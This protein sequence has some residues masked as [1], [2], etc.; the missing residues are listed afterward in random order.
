MHVRR[1]S[2]RMAM[3]TLNQLSEMSDW[4]ASGSTDESE[5]KSHAW[6]S[7]MEQYQVFLGILNDEERWQ[8]LS[9]VDHRNLVRKLG[10]HG[11][12]NRGN[13][14]L[15]KEINL[16][17]EDERGGVRTRSFT[18]LLDSSKKEN[19]NDIFS[20]V[21]HPEIRHV[22]EAQLAYQL[23][24]HLDTIYSLGNDSLESRLICFSA[25]ELQDID[26]Q[27]QGFSANL[28]PRM[29]RIQ[30]Q[31]LYSVILKYAPAYPSLTF[32]YLLD[33][34]FL[35]HLIPTQSIIRILLTKSFAAILKNGGLHTQ[36]LEQPDIPRNERDNYLT[37]SDDD[38]L[39]LALLESGIL[40][41][42]GKAIVD[43]T[44]VKALERELEEKEELLKQAQRGQLTL[45]KMLKDIFTTFLSD[46]SPDDFIWIPENFEL[47]EDYRDDFE[48][49]LGVISDP[50]YLSQVSEDEKHLT[51][52]WATLAESE[53][54]NPEV[55]E[56]L[57]YIE[58]DNLDRFVRETQ[59]RF[60][61]RHKEIV[62][63]NKQAVMDYM[64]KN[65]TPTLL[66]RGTITTPQLIRNRQD[67]VQ[68]IL[69]YVYNYLKG[70][71]AKQKVWLPSPYPFGTMLNLID[72]AKAQTQSDEVDP[73]LKHKYVLVH[74]ILEQVFER[75]QLKYKD[76]SYQST[77]FITFNRNR[78]VSQTTL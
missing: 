12:S 71:R 11:L 52:Y 23:L 30:L 62:D 69:G 34:Y 15:A 72:F 21:S 4:I 78:A 14:L 50:R 19:L 22:F 6:R 67:Q 61:V 74:E 47:D 7:R 24:E 55:R 43:Q 64:L 18:L 29:I 5:Y 56:S 20:A 13:P 53:Y 60:A 37:I 27:K 57:K 58:I 54:T 8:Q 42:S 65:M 26:E 46:K 32:Q 40:L 2:E 49:Y 1:A 68:T 38:S 33:G 75:E 25:R 36:D 16:K 77:S 44:Y 45:P 9:V 51:E 48:E 35:T 17:Y 31:A 41:D 10:T 28:I 76:P 3:S 39:T 63:Q 70:R 73:S 66:V 59:L